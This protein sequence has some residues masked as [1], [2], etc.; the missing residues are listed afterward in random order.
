MA[1]TGAASAP[2]TVLPPGRPASPAAVPLAE[3]APG[4]DATLPATLKDETSLI[5]VDID[6]LEDKP[7][8]APGAHLADYFNYGFDETTW[9]IYV[10]RQRAMRADVQKDQEQ[11]FKIFADMPLA[12]AWNALSPELK[13][14]MMQTIVGGG[15]GG[16]NPMMMMGMP[17]MGMPPMGMPPPGAFPQPQQQQPGFGGF[18]DP[19]GPRGTKRHRGDG[20]SFDAGNSMDGFMNHAESMDMSMMGQQQQQQQ[21]FNGDPQAMMGMMGDPSQL[22][23]FQQQQQQQN[24]AMM[25]GNNP[26]GRGGV[27]GRGGRGGGRGGRGRGNNPFGLQRNA[28]GMPVG[29]T[30]S[31]P[32]VAAPAGPAG[33]G[34]AMDDRPVSPLPGNVPT[35]PRSSNKPP[36]TGPRAGRKFHQDKDRSFSGGGSELDYGEG[37]GNGNGGRDGRSSRGSGYR[38]SRHDDSDE[39]YASRR[40]SSRRSASPTY[41]DYA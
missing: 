19:S 8:Q 23:S 27:G 17:P 10:A 41:E 26:A 15:P 9:K 20:E 30:T 12:D 5:D 35:G 34:G 16:M 7:W 29:G 2:T 31:A 32:G 4:F 14:Q 25:M 3:P 28:F 11:P 1:Q 37:G 13:G 36:P 24:M 38:R 21:A 22:D 40:R 39:E 33:E 6:A 18:D